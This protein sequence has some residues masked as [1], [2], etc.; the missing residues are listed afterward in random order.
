MQISHL[1]LAL[2]VILV[3]GF[4]FVAIKVG[5]IGLPPLLL[6]CA[7]FFLTS[8]PA[9]FFIKK[10]NASWKM[11][12]SYGLIMFALQFALLFMGMYAGVTPG[13]ASLLLQVHVFFST[14]LALLFF[15]EKLHGWQVG[16]ALLSFTGIGLI[17]FHL[18]GT[19]T[20][21][22]FILVIAA[23]ASWGAGNIISKKIGKVNMVSLVIWGSLIAWPPLLL[24]S[25]LVEG[26]SAITQSLTHLNWSSGGSVLYIT[27]LST[28]FGF[29]VWSWL[30]HHYPVSTVAPF[31]LAVPVLA[32]VSSMLVLGEPLQPWKIYSGAMILGG[33]CINLLGPRL[34]RRLRK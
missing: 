20:P 11:I 3:W 10:P 33:L 13:L 18:G 27:Y 34:F 22:G 14:F 24:L 6:C 5:L 4:N 29:G 23:A 9:I 12:I 19:I 17:G 26:P 31:T 25:L 28:L 32:M 30:L 8:I 16:G 7:R 21:I 15:Q 2:L 1:L